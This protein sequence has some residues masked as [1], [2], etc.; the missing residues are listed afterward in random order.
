MGAP[1]RTI[2]LTGSDQAV[3]SAGPVLYCGIVVA[4]TG[5]SN[6]VTVRVYDNAG[7]ASGTLIDAFNLNGGQSESR[8]YDRPIWCENGIYVDIGGTGTAAGSVRIG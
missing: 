7:A 3:R 1:A 5:G 2:A 4:E 8:M 6:A